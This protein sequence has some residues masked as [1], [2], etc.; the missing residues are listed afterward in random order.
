MCS[1]ALTA[2]LKKKINYDSNAIEEIIVT[3]LMPEPMHRLASSA[4]LITAEDIARAG[5]NSLPELLSQL[6]NVTLKSYTG[7]SK[8]SSIDIRGSGSTSVSNVL[9]LV[10]GVKMNASDLS[11]VDFSLINLQ[12]IERIEVIRGGNSVRYGSGASHGIINIITQK[13]DAENARLIQLSAGQHDD[14]RID[15]SIQKN[16]YKQYFS[17]NAS[18]A[19]SAGYRHHNQLNQHDLLLNYQT[20]LNTHDQFKFNSRL[21]RDTYEHPGSLSPLEIDNGIID[22]QAGSVAAGSEGKR[23]MTPSCLII[24]NTSIRNCY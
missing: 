13:K 17:I 21:H 22:R 4:S 3:G 12:H 6:A 2:L 7:N 10:D 1:Q 15:T 11:G 16:G 23:A 9:V 24:K 18:I 19:Q 20:E 8:S 5:A 14:Y